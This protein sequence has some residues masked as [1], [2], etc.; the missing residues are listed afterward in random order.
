MAHSA[1]HTPAEA[2]DL[3]RQ[4][5][6]EEGPFADLSRSLRLSAIECDHCGAE[7]Q[8]PWQQCGFCFAD[9]EDLG[10]RSW[11]VQQ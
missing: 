4:G 7:L 9:Q 1:A 11:E 3:Q 8:P 5:S 6:P 10:F 2:D